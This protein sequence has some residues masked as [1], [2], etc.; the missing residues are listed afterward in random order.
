MTTDTGNTEGSS[1]FTEDQAPLAALPGDVAT[2]SSSLPVSTEYVIDRNR[3]G[4]IWAMSLCSF[5]LVASE[6]MP[7]SLLTPIAG[8]LGI[9]E[10]RAGQTISISGLAAMA[11]ALGIGGVVR[12]VDRRLV[13]LLMAIMLVIS[14]VIVAAADSYPMMMVGRIILGLAIGGFWSMSAAM[15]MRLVEVDAVPRALALLNGGN[16]LAAVLGPPAGAFLGSVV[17]WRGAFFCVVPLGVLTVVWLYFALPSLPARGRS[18]GMGIVALLRRPSI[19]LGFVACALLFGGQFALYT[20]L[21]PFLEQVTGVSEM[22]LAWLLLLIGVSGFAGTVLVGNLIGSR[23]LPLLLAFPI[24]L[25]LLAMG[26]VLMGSSLVAVTVLL[27]LWGLFSVSAPV[28]WWVWV[29]RA[30]PDDPEAGGALV[31]AI[32]QFS[33]MAGASLGGIIYDA[34]GPSIEFLSCSA[35]LVMAAIV[36]WTSAPDRHE[37]TDV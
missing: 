2:A 20:Y 29:T 17:G 5:V 28:A 21:R 26:L 22:E 24:G 9:S 25:A 8:D 7:I 6:F 35:L 32:V 31:T 12:A 1:T 10:G 33:I 3:W 18:H 27:G 16:A 23:L 13:L 36:T 30:T 4:A 14:G 19:R 34:F 37:T 11:S 15:A